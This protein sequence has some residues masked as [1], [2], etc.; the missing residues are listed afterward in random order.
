[1]KRVFIPTHYSGKLELPSE[2]IKQLPQKLVLTM[3]VQFLNFKDK[4]IAQ[5]QKAG[6]KVTLFQ[7]QHGRYPGQVLGCD[8]F[9]FAGDYD[10]FLYIGDGKFHPTALLYENSLPVYCY[11]PFISK[12]EIIEPKY[13][14]AV[15]QRKQGMLAKFLSSDVIGII[16]TT[17]SGQ[18]QSKEAL[19]LSEKLR[20]SGK[21]AFVFLVDEINFSQLQNFNFIE[22]WINTGCPRIAE[23]FRCL[24][25]KDLVNSNIL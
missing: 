3:P 17:K 22:V 18:N 5:L 12:L 25:L 13:L 2:V 6:K 24:N 10:A 15:F 19:K 9:H 20:A 21:Q 14:D 1:M 8:V 4:I 7:S 23:D 16:C 11:N